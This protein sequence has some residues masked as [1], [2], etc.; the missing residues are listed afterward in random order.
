MKTSRHLEVCFSPALLPFYKT[1]GKTVVIIDI[2]RASSAICTA[3]GYGIKEIIPVQ[4]LDEA[5]TYKDK[6]F[7]TAAERDGAVAEGFDFGNSPYAFMEENLRGKSV[8]LT[9]TNCTIAI[10]EVK[11]AAEIIIAAFSNISAVEK[12]LRETKNDVLLLC[13]GWKNRFNL[14][15]S[16]FAGALVDRVFSEFS[17]ECDSAVASRSV[18]NIAKNDIRAYIGESSHTRRLRH[19]HIEKDIQYCLLSDQVVGVPYFDGKSIIL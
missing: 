11:N 9:T 19:L 15:D 2:F 16:I 14:E 6:G 18:F 7:I 17:I 13:A 5:K 8:V 3:L 4:T 1:E 10:H 12:Y